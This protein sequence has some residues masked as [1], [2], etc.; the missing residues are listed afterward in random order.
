[1]HA[2]FLI[3]LFKTQ[4]PGKP[5][6]PSGIATIIHIIPS[7]DN[8]LTSWISRPRACG[9]RARNPL[10]QPVI[11]LGHK[12]IIVAIPSGIGGLPIVIAF[13]WGY[14]PLCNPPIDRWIIVV[15]THVYRW[16]SCVIP[17]KFNS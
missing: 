8:W 17:L 5:P 9:P 4:L 10:G 2:H 15:I 1:M 11:A 16:I 12:W 3:E 13:L 6:M 14:Y 7:C